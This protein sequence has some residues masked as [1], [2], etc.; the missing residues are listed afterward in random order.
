VAKVIV[1]I[2]VGWLVGQAEGGVNVRAGS[3][4]SRL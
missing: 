4:E 1:V 2:D 3:E